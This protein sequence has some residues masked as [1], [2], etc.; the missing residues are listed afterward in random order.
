MSAAMKTKIGHATTSHTAH[1]GPIDWRQLV[2]WLQHDGVI[3]LEEAQRTVTR[4]SQAE[5]AQHP[6]LRLASVAM[7]RASDQKPLDVEALTQWLALRAGLAY[8]RSMSRSLKLVFELDG[9]AAFP[10]GIEELG[11]CPG[12]GCVKPS[13]GFQFDLDLGL[14]LAF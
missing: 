11:T 5:S 10:G 13:F 14:S 8:L 2:Q 1:Q 4:C 6:L 12:A 3:S 7:R 9:L